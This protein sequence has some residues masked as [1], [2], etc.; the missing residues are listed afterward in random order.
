MRLRNAIRNAIAARKRARVDSHFSE[1]ADGFTVIA[2]TDVTVGS[3]WDSILEGRTNDEIRE[4]F[5]AL[6]DADVEVT[7]FRLETIFP[8]GGN[9]RGINVWWDVTGGQTVLREWEWLRSENRPVLELTIRAQGGALIRDRSRGIIRRL[10][11]NSL[12]FELLDELDS[13]GTKPLQLRSPD[14]REPGFCIVTVSS[15]PRGYK[16]MASLEWRP[17]GGNWTLAE[18]GEEGISLTELFPETTHIVFS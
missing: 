12:T 14:F 8:T 2:G 11:R 4:Q 6:T 5:P 9:V 10:S 17:N 13:T 15:P 16:N 1:N 3:V 18:P 7:R